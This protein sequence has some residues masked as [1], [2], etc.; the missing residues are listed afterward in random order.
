MT[1]N[2]IKEWFNS[3]INGVKRKKLINVKQFEKAAGIPE[4]V[5]KNF[6]RNNGYI[7]KHST[8]IENLIKALK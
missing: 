5:L 4:N 6:L 3:E 8:K 7:E 1:A 2:E